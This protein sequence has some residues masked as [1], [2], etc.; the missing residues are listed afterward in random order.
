MLSRQKRKKKTLFQL[1][2]TPLTTIRG[3]AGSFADSLTTRYKSR[4][5]QMETQ[6]MLVSKKNYLERYFQRLCH[7]L[8]GRVRLEHEKRQTPIAPVIQTG[9]TDNDHR[10]LFIKTPNRNGW[11]FEQSETGW[12]VSNSERIVED[13][14]FIRQGEAWDTVSLYESSHPKI[15][16]RVSS[17]EVSNGEI[18]SF[19]VYEKKIANHILESF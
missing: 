16:C 10:Y 2:L 3:K 12:L 17:P 8:I 19:L 5:K 4:K 15:D 11:L 18:I 6:Y 1:F 9:W 14:T 13:N 7:S